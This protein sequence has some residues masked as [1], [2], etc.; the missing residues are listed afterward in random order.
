MEN[1]DMF[2]VKRCSGNLTFDYVHSAAVGN[3]GGILC[4]WD[5]NCFYKEN[6]TM[7]DSFVMIRG[8]W[9]STGQKY[10][11]IA[12]YA[13]YDTKDKHMLWDYLQRE[14]RRWKGEV[15][16]MGDFNEVRHKNTDLG[17]QASAL[18]R[19]I[20]SAVSNETIK[21]G[22]GMGVWAGQAA[23]GHAPDFIHAT[24]FL[25]SCILA[26][27]PIKVSVF[28]LPVRHSYFYNGTLARFATPT[29]PNLDVSLAATRIITG[30]TWP[31]AMQIREV[32]VNKIQFQKLEDLVRLVILTPIDD[33]WIWGLE[34]TGEFSV[35]SV[36]RLIDDKMLPRFGMTKRDGLIT[37]HLVNVH[38]WNVMRM[39]TSR[40]LF[41]SCRMAR[42]VMKLITRWW[43]VPESDFDSY[44]E[45]LAWFENVRMPL[46]NKK[47]L[48][49]VFAT[50]Y[51]GFW[52]FHYKTI[53]RV[54]L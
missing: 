43:N 25:A 19:S 16:V 37:S 11:L 7:S 52:W 30:Y 17:S 53:S 12:V 35:A 44:E 27:H 36:R 23:P 47:M 49:G 38:A 29:A 54:R 15:V 13:P 39:E 22:R 33:R 2:C 32:V 51:G 4:I 10:M 24:V 45:W 9:R 20:D 31:L 48:E 1:M 42:E 18:G 46:K 40:H 50:F 28:S 14:I 41:F 8:V 3:S 21:P 34:N 5:P 6:I 26:H